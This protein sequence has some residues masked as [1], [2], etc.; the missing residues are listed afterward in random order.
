[1]SGFLGDG[2]MMEAL[3][4]GITVLLILT[5]FSLWAV[6]YQVIKQHGQL[7]LRVDE[8]E[9]GFD[10]SAFARYKSGGITKGLPLN[11]PSSRS[12]GLPVG[13]FFGAFELPDLIG[14]TV[15]PEAFRGKQLLLVYWSP[16]CGFCELLAPELAG[17]QADCS[18][19]NIQLVLVSRDDAEANRALAEEH[20]LQCPILLLRRGKV[21]QGFAQ[22]GTPSAYLVD[23]EGRVAQPIAVG[24][25]EVLALVR[26]AIARQGKRLPGER[27][28]NES[29]IERSGLK[30]GTPAP[31]FELPDLN[32]CPISL[33]DY[34]GRRLLLA[35]TDPHCGPCDELISHLIRL[36]EVQQDN[37][38][39]VVM[40]G[41]GDIEENR[42]KFTTNELQFPVV[43][44]RRWELSKAYGIF[45]TPVAF[46]IDEDGIIARQVAI[47][48]Q[49]IMALAKTELARKEAGHEQVV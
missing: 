42:R 47:G 20:G 33:G 41:R 37:G 35:F 6:L 46:L 3:L 44:Q 4:G 29:R 8:M 45:Q 48:V 38:L 40:I 1:M 9:R 32:G 43:L 21:L 31:Q 19:R 24:G 22:A 14:Q 5:L 13:S 17:L 27:P 16:Q 18:K 23:G 39:A 2:G 15:S 30:P 11:P 10:Q 36:H 26:E 25:S 49:A 34:K 7:L 28:L 12:R